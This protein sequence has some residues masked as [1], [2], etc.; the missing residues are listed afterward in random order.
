MRGREA[1]RERNSQTAR[2]HKRR[3]Q[4]VLVLALHCRSLPRQSVSS[5]RPSYLLATVVRPVSVRFV[6]PHQWYL[7]VE[8]A[9]QRT[10]SFFPLSLLFFPSSWRGITL[11]IIASLRVS[12]GPRLLC[13]ASKT[14]PR[15]PTPLQIAPDPVDPVNCLSPPLT[16][17]SQLA[18]LCP[19]TRPILD[20]DRQRLSNPNIL[21][22]SRPLLA[23]LPFVPTAQYDTTPHSGPATVSTQVQQSS[24]L[25]RFA[26][27]DSLSWTTSQSTLA[28]ASNSPSR[29]SWCQPGRR[30]PSLFDHVPLICHYRALHPQLPPSF[31]MVGSTDVE[32]L[33][34]TGA[35][36]TQRAKTPGL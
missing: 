9:A 15:T 7:H 8:V 16:P 33:L 26:L 36:T 22:T 32:T 5:A 13:S 10:H 11:H 6:V 35:W 28:P 31:S 21:T 2:Q 24:N 4:Y 23:L 30:Y 19:S 25:C 18:V 1:Q 20:T 34:S 17:E 27:S 14:P 3:P 12:H 29:P